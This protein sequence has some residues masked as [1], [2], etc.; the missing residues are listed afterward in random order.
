MS[1]SKSLL[2]PVNIMKMIESRTADLGTMS[3]HGKFFITPGAQIPHRYSR[4]DIS[5]SPTL[6]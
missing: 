1:E 4:L 3:H 6:M 5:Q 2:H